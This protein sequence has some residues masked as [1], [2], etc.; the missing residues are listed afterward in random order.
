[1]K[2]EEF[3]EF[4]LTFFWKYNLIFLVKKMN[5]RANIKNQMFSTSRIHIKDEYFS[6]HIVNV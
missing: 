4:L 3:E 6:I 1:M 2:P 5:K